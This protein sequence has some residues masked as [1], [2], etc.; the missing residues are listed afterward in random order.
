MWK[1]YSTLLRIQDFQPSMSAYRNVPGP[2][3]HLFFRNGF[4]LLILNTCFK[5]CPSFLKSSCSAKRSACLFTKV[6][7][8]YQRHYFVPWRYLVHAVEEFLTLC[9]PLST[10]I[11][12]VR[13][14]YPIGHAVAPLSLLRLHY[15]TSQEN[16]D[17]NHLLPNNVVFSSSS[18]RANSDFTCCSIFTF[19]ILSL[20]MHFCS[21][22]HP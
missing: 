8:L 5:R 14:I 20:R 12:A 7:W 17:V 1:T 2:S 13:K 22:H 19:L 3:S 21:F 18:K 6:A 11:L 16:R 4:R 15:A 9:E 10:G